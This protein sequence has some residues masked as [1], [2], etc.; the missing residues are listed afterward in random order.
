MMCTDTKCLEKLIVSQICLFLKSND[1]GDISLGEIETFVSY[2]YPGEMYVTYLWVNL[3]LNCIF[4]LMV[5]ILDLA[6]NEI[7]HIAFWYLKV[8]QPLLCFW[9]NLVFVSS[10]AWVFMSWRIGFHASLVKK[11]NP[12]LTRKLF[13]SLKFSP[14]TQAVHGVTKTGCL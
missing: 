2:S 14:M 3:I 12:G 7:F 5:F 11:L 4:H 9:V 13:E 1:S 6:A 10:H 8:T